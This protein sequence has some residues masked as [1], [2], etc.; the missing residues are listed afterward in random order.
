MRRL[1]GVFTTLIMGLLT[2]GLVTAAPASAQTGGAPPG[3]GGFYAQR[4]AWSACGGGFQCAKLKVPVNYAK[5]KG[6][7]IEIAVIRLRAQGP[8]RIGSL[9]LNPGGPGGSGVAMARNAKLFLS[10]ALR[11]SFDI[12]GFDPR[13]V[14]LSAPVR[15]MSPSVLDAYHALDPTPDTPTEVRKGDLYQQAYAQGCKANTGGLLAHL[16]TRSAARDIDV[17]RAALGEQRLTYLGFSYGS[18]L[19]AT[20]A[21]LFPKRVRAM[22]LD[23]A[24][25][26]TTRGSS[27]GSVAHSFEVAFTAFLRDCYRAP[28]CP[29]KK[30]KVSASFKELAGLF[31]RAD[32]AP[33]R[34]DADGR[35]VNEAL[36]WRGVMASM[37]SREQWPALRAALADAFKGDGTALLTF[38]DGYNGRL[39][40]GTY[41][42]GGEAF[43]AINCVDYPPTSTATRSQVTY[44]PESRYFGKYFSDGLLSPCAFWPVKGTEGV[45]RPLRAKGAPPILVVGTTRDPATPY[46]DAKALAAQLSSGVLLGFDGDGHTAYGGPSTCVNGA[47][48]RYLITR[49]PPKDGTFCAKVTAAR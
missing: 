13:G 8:K 41:D 30:H 44:V 12:V 1:I 15:C 45:G 47:V 19:G 23:G 17:L 32:R 26:P 29:F 24:I 31:K 36:V 21:D 35:Q 18:L 39:G 33:L 10:P 38:A 40:D 14:G 22:V 25:D 7:H 4:L 43:V 3:L 34:N 46:K 5:P 6:R 11:S 42:N 27:A 20:Y 28:G 2:A 49:V 37:Y 16:G 48:D 9:V